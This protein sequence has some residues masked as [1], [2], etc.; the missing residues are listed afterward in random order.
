MDTDM[1]LILG[2]LLLCLSIPSILSALSDRRAPRMGAFLVLGGVGLI[3]WAAILHPGGYRPAD[4]PE[5]FLS[6]LARFIP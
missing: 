5:V 1:A 6:V 3:L 4:V 2:L